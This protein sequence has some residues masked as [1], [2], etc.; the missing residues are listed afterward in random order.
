MTPGTLSSDSRRFGPSAR[1][2]GQRRALLTAVKLALG[3]LA[4]L[5]AWRFWP[6]SLGAALGLALGLLA[7]AWGLW[8]WRGLAVLAPLAERELRLHAHAL[9][10]RRGDFKRFVVFES[11]R[12]I[13]VVQAPRGERLLSLRLDTDDDSL[14][15]RD[16]DGLPE[17]FAA[18]AGAKPDK[19]L[20][21]ID[22]QRVDWGEPLPWALALT[23]GI[24]ILGALFV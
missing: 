13:R 21:E 4:G 16:L 12:H 14:L 2:L 5:L 6:A 8:R 11:L 3:A 7:L 9:E 23:A 20:I 1:A 15:L 22:E 18:I 17:A 19:T 24:L 10:L